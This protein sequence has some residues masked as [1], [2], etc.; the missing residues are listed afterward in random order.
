MLSSP[1]YARRVGLRVCIRWRNFAPVDDRAPMTP[2]ALPARVSRPLIPARRC[3]SVAAFTG[4]RAV[5]SARFRVRQY[6]PALARLGVTVREFTAP[7]GAYPP[8]SRW[9]RPAWGA[10]ALASLLPGVVR[11]KRIR[12]HPAAA[13]VPVHARHARAAYTEAEGARRGRR[14]SPVPRGTPCPATGGTVRRC[15]L[16]QCIPGRVVQQVESANDRRADGCR[17]GP[18]CPGELRVAGTE[19]SSSAGLGPPGMPNTSA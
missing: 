5:P 17:Y 15:R 9:L 4:G 12:H 19:S 6:I 13:G 18:L 14:D 8:A 16:R 11:S 2:Q 10:T 1:S 3:L 7:L